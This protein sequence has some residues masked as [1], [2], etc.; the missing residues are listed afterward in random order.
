[1]RG[2]VRTRIDENRVS[3]RMTITTG[4]LMWYASAEL[5]FLVIIRYYL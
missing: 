2:V 5:V 1:M 4:Q 3:S